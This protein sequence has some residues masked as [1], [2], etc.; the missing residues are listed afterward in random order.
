MRRL[1]PLDEGNVSPGLVADPELER[2]YAYPQELVRAWVRVGFVSS[3]DGGVTVGGVAEGL[4]SPTDHRVFDL[5][6][7]LADVVLVGAGTVRN[8]GYRGVRLSGEHQQRRL[9]RGQAAV[10]PI[11]VVTASCALDPDS[12]LFTETAVPPLIFTTSSASAQRRARLAAAGAVV[13]ML[14]TERVE[15]TRLLSHLERCGLPRVL[16]EGGP[17]LHGDLIAASAVDELCLTVSPLLIGSQATRIAAGPAPAELFRMHLATIL[18]ED[19][20]LLLRY[21]RRASADD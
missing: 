17:R 13:S 7:S 11:A 19:H 12:A 2:C 21:V 5:L 10:P 6:R 18:T 16:C 15:P 4:S 20:Q 3:V 1:W 14:G 9:A 8:E